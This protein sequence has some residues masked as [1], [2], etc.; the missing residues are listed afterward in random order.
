M[1]RFVVTWLVLSICI[2][3]CAVRDS[4]KRTGGIGAKIEAPAE[5][6]AFDPVF[7]L[8]PVDQGD[9]SACWCFATMSFLESEAARLGLPSV[10]LAMMYPMYYGFVEKAKYFVQTKGQSRFEPGDL[11]PTVFEVVQKYG[12]VPEESFPARSNDQETYNQKAMYTELK[13]YVARVKAEEIWDQAKVV[14][15]VESILNRHMGKPPE[16]FEY[17]GQS[18][19]PKSFQEK[20]VALPWQDYLLVTSFQYAPFYTY[21]DLRVPDNWHDNKHYYNVPLEKFMEGLKDAVKTGYSVA[22]D[23]DISEPGRLG[24]QDISIIPDYDIPYAYITQEAREYRF[25]QKA[26]EDDHLMHIVGVTKSNGH[27]WFLVKDSWRDAWKGRHKGYFFFR[28][29]YVKLKV[30]AYLVHKDALPTWKLD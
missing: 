29:D 14:A 8:P 16:M 10:R 25:Q 24:A 27:D 23:S 28:D 22:F 1:R 7:H 3:G 21:T 9:T 20:F 6:S 17:A 18:Y 19:T 30:L 4:G 12:I 15:E 2:C 26:T 13:A 5:I 11:F